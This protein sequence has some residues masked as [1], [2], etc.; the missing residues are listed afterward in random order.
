LRQP[1]LGRLHR[2]PCHEAKPMKLRNLSISKKLWMTTLAILATMSAT[3]A[4]TQHYSNQSLVEAMARVESHEEL[5]TMSTRWKGL[6]DANLERVLA[7]SLSTDPVISQTF[8]PKVKAGSAAIGDLQKQ[9][10]TLAT[11]DDDKAA[12]DKVALARAPVL[13][14]VT[15]LAELKTAGDAA[16][17]HDEIEQFQR[18]HIAN[19]LA[20]LDEFIQL[21]VQHREAAKASAE[22]TRRTS[23]YVGLGVVGVVLLI[24]LSW[25]ALLSRS[26][27]VP[28][29]RAV[30]VSESIAGGD[31]TQRLHTDRHD[32][33]GQL[34]QAMSTMSDKL[35]SLVCEVR[36][37]VESVNSASSDI[38]TGNQDLSNRTEQAASS[39]EQTASAMEQLTATVTQSA[40]TA[41]QANEWAATAASAATKGGHVVHQVVNSMQ[42]I[43]G[44]SRKIAD[45]IG[46]ID[47]IAFQTNILALNAAVEAARAGEQ[48]RGFAVVAGE[49]RVLAQRSAAAAKEIKVLI[50]TSVEEVES[51]AQRVAEAGSAMDEIV[52][53]VQRMTGMM[54]DIAAA[55]NEQRDGIAQVNLAV[56]HL[57]QMTQQ[58]AA[59]VEESA[60]AAS[61][62]REQ[63]NRLTA[64]V[65][66]FKVAPGVQC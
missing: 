25:V 24:S 47:G 4:L 51:G 5:I 2:L 3:A 32:E 58:N 62:L 55:A 19:Y 48:G 61:S 22:A 31:L 36:A 49:V 45:I 1:K 52:T 65:S 9:L 23:M 39:L 16:A 35:R 38:A 27:R 56:T 13:A 57:D 54:G 20:A 12:M 28:L 11:A 21:Q 46:T 63:A 60:A 59:L 50:G 41:R 42:A 66:E 10:R 34:M 8:G 33:V 7:N 6:V 17:M 30:R 26:I 43:T 18:V 40:E 29:E 15:K 37:G 64:V 14:A 44:S 53:S